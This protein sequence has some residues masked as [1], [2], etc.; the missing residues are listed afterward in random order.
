MGQMGI[1]APAVLLQNLYHLPDEATVAEAMDSRAFSEFC[2]V[3]SSNQVPDGDTPGRFRTLLM[4]SGLQE[5]LF[6]RLWSCFRP[7][8]C[9]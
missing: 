7:G 3:D 6:A 2:G 1:Y 5:K 8:A 9:C 4:R